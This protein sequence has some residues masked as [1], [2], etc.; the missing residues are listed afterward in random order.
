MLLH[1]GECGQQVQAHE[2]AAI[3][4]IRLAARLGHVVILTMARKSWVDLCLTS[5]LPGVAD[6]IKELG[7]EIICARQALAKRFW[8]SAFTNERNP[9]QFFKTKAM[10]IIIKQFLANSEER[11]LCNALCALSEEEFQLGHEP[12]VKHMPLTNVVS[13]GDSAGER[14]ALQDICF[15]W[16]KLYPKAPVANCK[17]LLMWEHPSIEELTKQ[18]QS[19][20]TSLSELLH[21]DWDVDE[22]LCDARRLPRRNSVV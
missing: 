5:L 15:R 2:A 20:M 17:T 18:L 10:E 19:M 9:S 22:D 16:T 4:F 21:K 1:T 11:S 12:N 13:I 7:I 14:R 3:E 6:V 8:R